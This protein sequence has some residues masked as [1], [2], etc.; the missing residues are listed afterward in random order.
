MSVSDFRNRAPLLALA[1][2][3]LL[4]GFSSQISDIVSRVNVGVPHPGEP[5]RIEAELINAAVIER[6]EIAYRSFGQSTFRLSEMSLVGNTATVVIP[7]ADLAPPFLEYYI[8]LH[9]RDGAATETFPVLTPAE[10]PLKVDLQAPGEGGESS[11]IILSPEQ[12]DNIAPEDLYVSYSLLRADSTVDPANIKTYID[13]NDVSQNAVRSGN[14]VVVRPAVNLPPGKHTIRVDVGDGKGNIQETISWEFS[15]TEPGATAP[16]MGPSAWTYHYSAQAETRN[17]S[18]QDVVTPFNRLRVSGNADYGQYRI[19]GNVYL[20]N[21]EKDTRQPQNRYFIGAEASWLKLGYGDHYPVFPEFIMNGIR[22]RGLA[23]NL[24]LGTFNL[25]VSQGEI[26]RHVE[27]DTIKTFPADSLAAEQQR[28]PTGAY[29][30]YDPTSVPVRWA[31]FSYGTY[32][33]SL[34]AVRPSFG[35]REGGHIGFSFLKSKDDMGSIKYGHKPKENAVAGT[36]ILMPFDNHKVE[37]TAEA[38][39]SATNEDITNGT[40]SD[41]QIDSIFQ[42]LGPDQIDNIKKIRNAFEKVITVNENLVPLNMTNTPTLAYEGALALNYFDNYFKF[43]YLRHGSNFESFG[44]AFTRTDVV[45][46]NIN[47]HL[48]LMNGQWQLTG[49]FERLNDNTAN[50][51]PATTTFTTGSVSVGY[52]PQSNA[53]NV[54]LAYYLASSLNDKASDTLFGV[55]DQS[56]RILLQLG[57]DFM[58]GARHNASAGISFSNRDDHT[59][60]NLDTKNTTL[61]LSNISTFAIALQTILSLNYV[62]NSFKVPSGGPTLKDTTIG[63]TTLFMQATYRMFHEKLR[64]M[65]AL[66]PTFGDIERTMIDARAQYFILTNLSL[67]GQSSFYLN[68]ATTND[69]IWSFILRLDM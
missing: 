63:Y 40:F 44:Q 13:G 7:A 27:S 19:L 6:V 15:S 66:S 2:F 31:K 16:L 36:D 4:T 43:T 45:G 61:T 42:D 54:T 18:I 49:G 8:I 30:V 10:H 38:A 21:E 12:N 52:F 69:Y 50:T 60:N 1:L 58:L 39:F 48:R 26:I 17:E 9:K 23:G 35:N 33:R 37:I 59:V 51:K 55:D 3:F 34:F 46:Y 62:S 47:D 57:K 56:N 29:G 41:E 20:T 11:I 53:P 68:K 25:D 14:L 64:L 5:L 22:V 32:D 67:I 24:T 28:D 65:G